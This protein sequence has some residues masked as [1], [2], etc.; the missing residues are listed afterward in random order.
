MFGNVAL[1][2]LIYSGLVRRDAEMNL[3]GDLA[4]LWETPDR[5]SYAFHYR[6]GVKFHNGREVTARDVRAT[7]EFMRNPV[8]KS[9]RSGAFR[10]IRAIET[11]V[12]KTVI[13][14]LRE[15]YA[16]FLW[17]LEKPAV[18]VVPDDARAVLRG[19]RL[20]GDRFDL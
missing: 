7:I 11:P 19:I 16:S 20:G 3:H 6:R 1:P 8:N 10:M 18:G 14:H 17:N 4:E 9:P 12:A 13:F 2:D 15:G 5:V